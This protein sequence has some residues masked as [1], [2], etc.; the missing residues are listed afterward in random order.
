MCTTNVRVGKPR[1]IKR[2]VEISP[3]W[4]LRVNDAKDWGDRFR[5]VDSFEAARGLKVL[6]N[7]NN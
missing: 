5:I 1:E 6:H 3:V 4:M 7:I 2:F